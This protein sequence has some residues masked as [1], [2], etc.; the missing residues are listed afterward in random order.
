MNKVFKVCSS[1]WVFCKGCGVVWE[2]DNKTKQKCSVNQKK[3]FVF[4]RKEQIC[5]S[6]EMLKC[7]KKLYTEMIKMMAIEILK[8]WN[9][10]ILKSWNVEIFKYWNIEMMK[11]CNDQMLTV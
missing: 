8:Y 7:Q 9:A 2:N 4:L 3:S 6:A 11:S 5:W 1:S 10:E